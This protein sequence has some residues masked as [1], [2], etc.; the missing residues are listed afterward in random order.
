MD[1]PEPP[2]ADIDAQTCPLSETDDKVQEAHYFLHRA[3]TSYH[4]PEEFR[5]NLNAFLQALRSVTLYLQNELKET[6]GFDTW[7]E[8][9]REGLRADELLGRFLEGRNVVAHARSLD[10][11][12]TVNAGVFRGRKLKLGLGMAIPPSRSSAQ[13][14]AVMQRQLGWVDDEHSFIGEQYGVERTWVVPELD[15]DGEVTRLCHSAWA[16]IVG[17]IAA[18]H[19]FVGRTHLRVRDEPT[20]AHDY[21]SYNVLLESDLDPTA[22][23]RWGW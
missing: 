15:R 12:S 2:V 21:H 14:I 20:A 4:S 17:V 11:V 16:R 1:G 13:L 10:S 3:L 22:A 23:E 19:E 7:Y 18:A 5:W 9:V 8:T 6:D